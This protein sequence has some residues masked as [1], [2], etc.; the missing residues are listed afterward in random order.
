M[1]ILEFE[2]NTIEYKSLKKVFGKN[3][4]LKDLAKTCVCLAN[5]QGGYL[6]L[7]IE[8]KDKLP[9]Q[10]QK[11]EQEELNK[12]IK[13]LRKL[14]DSVGLVN[15]EIES[16]ENGA[17][18][19]V[20]KVLPSLKTIATTTDGKVYIR[21]GD[22]CV[23]IRGEELTRL[24][25]EKGAFQWELVVT[26]WT[27]N[28]IPQENITKFINDIRNSDRVSDF[29]KDKESKEILEYYHLI[30]E[31]KVTNLGILWLGDYKQR[32]KLNYPITVQYIV[33]NEYEEKIRKVEWNLNQYNPKELLLEIEK[34]AIELNYSF[35]IPNGLFRK[36]VRHYNK[37]VIRELLINA[38][39]HKSYTI[40]GDIFIS[41]YKDRLEIKSPGGL[42]LGVTKNNILHQ[43]QR[44][45][46]KLID[47]F[48]ALNLMES[49]GSGYDL[50]YEK[51]SLDGKK[52]PD[53]E[54]DINYMKVTIY[55]N[56]VDED[57]LQILDF[58]AKHYQ[59]SQKEIITLGVIIREKKITGFELAKILQLA[60]DERLR[61][62]ISSLVDKNIVLTE[63]KTKGLMYMI[64]PKI[65]S[66]M[67]H[68]LK[69][70][71]K[72]MEEYTL[73]ALIKEDLKAHPKSKISEIHKRMDD[74]DIKYLRKVIYRMVEDEELD[75]D[76]A[77]KNRVYFL[78]NKKEN[79]K[80]YLATADVNDT[81]IVNEE[82][83]I[84][85]N[86]RPSRANMQPIH[87]SIWFAG[88]KT[89]TLSHNFLWAF[90]MSEEFEKQ[91]DNLAN[92]AVQIAINNTNIKKINFIKPNNELLEIFNNITTSIFQNIQNNTQQIQTL[93]QTRDTLLPKLI[94]REIEVDKLDIREIE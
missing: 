86:N 5:A 15:P 19:A 27:L 16:W 18:Y 11:I 56:I 88:I 55:S 24:A 80:V 68:N 64:N 38:F 93:Q 44:R 85:Y 43:V 51:L 12:V 10:N 40:S 87:K 23:P 62:W 58:L 59:L 74:L 60:D 47:T 71:L 53:I 72:T 81:N 29:I 91:K 14:T 13:T 82:V 28:D 33:Y 49:E 9:P 34:E 84:T 37:A 22:E 90:I 67:E 78:A 73:K 50:I 6:I 31:M 3:S 41:V 20:I 21:V 77:N 42:P 35:E 54:T 7:G 66:S 26:R 17:E 63:G 70:S 79:E 4:N 76:G 2:T 75:T 36:Q 45:N 30:D 89:T 46:P 57:V 8:D 69:P 48:K 39:A 32:S 83:K 65:L 25:H 1:N 92:G 52:F 94:N 61:S